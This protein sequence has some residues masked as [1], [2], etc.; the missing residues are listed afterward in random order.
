MEAMTNQKYE[1]GTAESA[2]ENQG[3]HTVEALVAM[4]I[5]KGKRKQPCC[6]VETMHH[7]PSS[8]EEELQRKSKIASPQ[9]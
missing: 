1:L 5:C 2:S 8:H 4:G 3:E 9:P 6:Q 7:C